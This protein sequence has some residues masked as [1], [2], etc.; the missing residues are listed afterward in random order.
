VSEN[1]DVLPVTALIAPTLVAALFA[2]DAGIVPRRLV[3]RFDFEESAEFNPGVPVNFY[4]VTSERP[5]EGADGDRSF[6]LGYPPFGEVSTA[7]GVGRDGRGYAVRF[8]LD[9]AS[10]VLGRDIVL[11]KVPVGSELLVRAWTKTDGLRHASVRVSARY[12]D[13]EGLPIAGIHASGLVRAEAE[14]RPL[15]VEPPPMPPRARLLQLWLEVVQ[16]RLE[17]SGEPDRL[18]VAKSDV[19]GRAYFATSRSG[20]CPRSSSRRRG[21]A[22]SRRVP[23]RISACA[24]TIRS[25]RSRPPQCACAMLAAASRSSRRWS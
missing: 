19:R 13:A 3:A 5:A 1:A 12:F 22:S 6:A 20:R 17:G 7:S 18:E 24:A 10:M 15:E 14:W 25:S 8:E 11:D 21:L 9:G 16:P 4:R 23:G 2:Q